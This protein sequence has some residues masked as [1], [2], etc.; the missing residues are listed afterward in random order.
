[1]FES[2]V[3]VLAKRKWSLLVSEEEPYFIASDRP[4]VPHWTDGRDQGPLEQPG[5]GVPGTTVIAPL[6]KTVAIL[7]QFEEE[8]GVVPADR[9][10][11]AQ[12]NSSTSMYAHRHLFAPTPEHI[13]RTPEG[14]VAS[15]SQLETEIRAEANRTHESESE[16]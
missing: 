4:V 13:Y 7:G 12:V 2:A 15:S 6:H 14:D 3:P 5:L 9:K 10:L 1:M 11:V 16:C 8:F